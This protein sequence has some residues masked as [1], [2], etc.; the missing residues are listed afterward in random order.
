M[1]QS[2]FKPSFIGASRGLMKTGVFTIGRWTASSHDT[3]EPHG[4]DDPHFI[5][6]L[7]GAFASVTDRETLS[8]GALIFNPAGTFHADHF[9]GGRGAFL[10]LT[11]ND[12]EGFELEQFRPPDHPS[13]APNE[14]CDRLLP[15]L[16]A[17]CAS[18]S[19]DAVDIEGLAH[20][21]F[22]AV[23]E[24]APVER[25][26]PAW[27]GRARDRLRDQDAASVSDVARSVGV[28]PIHL[29]RV[30][31]TVQGCTPGEYQR[32]WR[33]RRA[34]ALLDQTRLPVAEVAV[35]AGFSDQSHLT[36]QFRAVFGVGPA[37]YRRLTA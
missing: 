12:V 33:L 37:G 18:S 31:R 22:G 9:I 19:A 23:C 20:D 25:G 24:R 1:S 28:H 6:I 27:L 26:T 30:F 36:R 13:L 32:G 14:A 16:M 34:A 7:S 8:A 10:S 17:A 4:H 2:G 3:V 35:R 15:R 21:L 29:T 5:W 11:L